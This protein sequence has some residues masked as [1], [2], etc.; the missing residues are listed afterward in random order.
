MSFAVTSRKPPAAE[1]MAQLVAQVRIAMPFDTP[2]NELCAGPCRGCPKKLL[3][4]LDM[5]LCDW[6][7]RLQAKE[8]PSLGDVQCLAKLSRKIYSALQVNGLVSN[9]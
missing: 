2:A 1:A 9:G 8:Q 5:E 3:E 4:Y 6:Q 7:Q